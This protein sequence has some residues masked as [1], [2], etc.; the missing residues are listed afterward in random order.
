MSVQHVENLSDA[1]QKAIEKHAGKG[2]VEIAHEL[3]Q[4]QL[5]LGAVSKIERKVQSLEREVTRL[6]ERLAK[7]QQANK[8]LVAENGELDGE[9]NQ[10]TSEL[11]NVRAEGDQKKQILK[12][13]SEDADAL[14]L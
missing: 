12:K 14:G 3:V 5:Q 6:G 4:A 10:L 2:I 11:R 9:I 1:Q 13:A 7:E 8:R